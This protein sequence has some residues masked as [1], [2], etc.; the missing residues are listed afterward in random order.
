MMERGEA[1]ATPQF[2]CE[3]TDVEASEPVWEEKMLES[4]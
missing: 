3:V 1:H 4:N 2:E